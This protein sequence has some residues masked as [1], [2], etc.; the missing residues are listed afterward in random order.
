MPGNSPI[1]AVPQVA[2]DQ[3]NKY[4]TINDAT[5]ALESVTQDYIAFTSVGA[6]DVTLTDDEATRY[7]IYE[8]SG[9]TGNFDL[10]FPAQNVDAQALRRLFV[11]NNKDTAYTCNVVTDAAG[12]AI[13]VKPGN[14]ALLQQR[15]NDVILIGYFHDLMANALP[16]DVGVFIP[17]TPSASQ[18]CLRYTAVRA[19]RFAD[20]FASS[21]ANVRTNP[22]ATT[23]FDIKKN[24]TTIGTVAFSTAGA[25]T[26]T[27][28]GTG[29]E[30]FAAG[31]ILE[32]V[33]PGTPDATIADIS[34]TLLGERT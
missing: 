24:G 20:N 19:F 7:A 26:F 10:I 23:T 8:V 1:L 17:G 27:T 3:N 34:I 14:K 32:I 11:V 25:P 6:G 4:I 30:T 2:A 22:T 21:D 31:D 13:V 33:A 16:Y 28:S 29:Y 5:E 12:A 18:V 15:G 9:A